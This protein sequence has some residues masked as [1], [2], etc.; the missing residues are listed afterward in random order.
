VWID[1]ITSSSGVHL[2]MFKCRPFFLERLGRKLVFSEHEEKQ[3]NP[4][5]TP[6]T[7]EGTL[8]QHS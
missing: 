1:G 6:V 5:P 7:S 8:L 2:F 4:L 3:V